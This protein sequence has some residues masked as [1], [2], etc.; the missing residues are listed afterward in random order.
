VILALK[1]VGKQGLPIKLIYGRKKSESVT[2]MPEAEHP[3][4]GKVWDL[5]EGEV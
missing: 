1:G 5:D 2:R 4:N 3:L